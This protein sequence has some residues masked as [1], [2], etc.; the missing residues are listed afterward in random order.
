[1]PS[2]VLSQSRRRRSSTIGRREIAIAEISGREE[3]GAH[4]SG[5]LLSCEISRSA[6]SLSSPAA[7]TLSDG[8]PVHKSRVLFQFGISFFI[9]GNFHIF[10]KRTSIDAHN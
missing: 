1:M 8:C 9:W 3:N 4:D 10:R 5:F 7:E 2:S 6:A